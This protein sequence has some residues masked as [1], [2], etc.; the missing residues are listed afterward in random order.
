MTYGD[1]SKWNEMEVILT[2]P[3][4][5]GGIAP[6]FEF[7]TGGAGF[8]AFSPSDG[9]NGLR[10]TGS[11]LWV[12]ADLSG[13]ATNASGR[14]E[15]R[16]TR[17]RNS[18]A[19][20]PVLD[21]VQ[22]SSTTEFKWDSAGDVNINSLSLVTALTVPNGGTGAA[23][24]TDGGILLGSGTGALTATAQPASGQ[25]LIGSVGVDPVLATLTAGN[26]VT[27]TEGAGSITIAVN[28]AGMTWTDVTGTSQAMAVDNGYIANNAGLVTLTLP[29]VAVVGD[30]VR[31]DGAGA[32]GWLIAQNAGQTVRMLGQSTTT[33]AG[34]SLAST[35]QYDCVAYRCIIANTDWVVESVMGNLTVV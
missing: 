35:T 8:T 20:D 3:A 4:S 10:N 1:A 19:T 22:L 30:I 12:A 29:A 25:L 5:G 33:G 31:V 11:I 9:T 2:T 26:G 6:T 24:F 7:S 34:G 18:L 16:H 27:I 28:D 13:W 23:T 15:I 32:G 17:T 21:E 14:F